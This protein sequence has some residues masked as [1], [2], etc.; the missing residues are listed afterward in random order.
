MLFLELVCGKIFFLRLV[1]NIVLYFSFLVVWMVISVIVFLVFLFL[2][3]FVSRFTWLRKVF[4]E[5][6]VVCLCY[7]LIDSM[8]SC[9]F[10]VRVCVFSVFFFWSRLRYVVLLRIV[11]VIWN[12]FFLFLV[13]VWSVVISFLK[14]SMVRFVRFFWLLFVSC[15]KLLKR[16]V[17][18]LVASC[19][20]R[21]S[22]VLLIF[23]VGMLMMWDRVTLF[24]GFCTSWR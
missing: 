10:L 24:V 17:F 16:L 12:V 18:W 13:I 3:R 19:C 2:F 4:R 1:M 14:W 6:S 21:S 8:S 23:C 20:V 15:I 11:S 22:V 7:F 5:W 9:M